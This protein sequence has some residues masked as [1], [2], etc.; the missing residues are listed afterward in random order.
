MI[1]SVKVQKSDVFLDSPLEC[2]PPSLIQPNELLMIVPVDWYAINW[3]CGLVNCGTN[4]LHECWL[5]CQNKIQVFCLRAFI[6]TA[7]NRVR[8]EASHNFMWLLSIKLRHG[9]VDCGTNILHGCWL[10]GQNEIQGYR[11]ASSNIVAGNRVSAGGL[12]S[13]QL[14]W[15]LSAKLGLWSWRLRY[16]HPSRLLT[17]WPKQDLGLTPGIFEYLCRVPC[18]ISLQETKTKRKYDNLII[19]SVL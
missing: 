1:V 6:I 16:Q 18:P 3:D 4:I 14:I 17:L 7:G 15:L 8:G 9:P 10:F 2:G 11:W 12:T 19:M 5:F 13:C